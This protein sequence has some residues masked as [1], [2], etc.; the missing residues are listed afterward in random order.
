MLK[1]IF[2]ICFL[3]I[4]IC[5][6]RSQEINFTTALFRSG[7]DPAWSKASIDESQWR[8]VSIKGNDHYQGIGTEGTYS[9]YR[10][11][12]RLD[13]HFDKS[14]VLLLRLGYI[15][16]A[17]ETYLNG[18]QVGSSSDWQQPRIY[19]VKASS[20]KPGVDNVIAIRVRNDGGSG[21]I[22]EG[23]PGW[24]TNGKCLEFVAD[25][26]ECM[27]KLYLEITS[28]R[29]KVSRDIRSFAHYSRYGS[30]NE[31]L[32]AP[33]EGERR[34]VLMGDSITDAW[35]G[36]RDEFFRT[37]DIIGRG[38]GGETSSQFLLR[39]R[40]DVIDLHPT[41][42][43]INYGTNDIAENTGTYDENQT[44][45][46][47]CAM[48]EMARGAGIRVV[49]TSTLPHGGF[50]WNQ[51]ITDAMAKVRSLNARVR[52]YAESEGITFV[53]YF[54]SMVSSDGTRMRED[55][56]SDGVHPNAD[57]YSI[58]EHLLLPVIVEQR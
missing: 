40:N 1:R 17:D 20:L 44:F 35:P 52:K 10:I 51:K 36:K 18:Y 19:T 9:W 24:K 23:E 31:M 55:L 30:A 42:V 25:P 2:S 3:G 45:R 15:D 43:V 5:I 16:D 48:C 57:G 27:S 47:V 39:F 49:L 8:E 11:H 54:S 6:A 32:G 14:S 46:N 37:N 7:D 26:G 41:L 29:G 58:M 4:S 28:S 13:K 50:L 33:K 53:D 21:G 38:I 12:F 56:S 34:V 22:G